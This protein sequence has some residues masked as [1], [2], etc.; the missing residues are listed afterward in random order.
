MVVYGFHAVV[1]DA[2]L[3]GEVPAKSPSICD[4]L[5]VDVTLQPEKQCILTTS[6]DKQGGTD[7]CIQAMW[8][9]HANFPFSYSQIQRS[10]RYGTTIQ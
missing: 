8:N 2:V 4:Q 1:S 7:G 9:S 5:R 3:D 6:I 10:V